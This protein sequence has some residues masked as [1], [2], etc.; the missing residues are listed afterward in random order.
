MFKY[1]YVRAEF[2]LI[3][4][5]D[6]F[7]GFLESP[8]QFPFNLCLLIL[9]S[10]VFLFQIIEYIISQMHLFDILNISFF[11]FLSAIFIH[12]LLRR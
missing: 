9:F 8:L 1:H 12:Q 10:I 6:F 2:A 7:L 4:R 5:Y 3:Y 11:R